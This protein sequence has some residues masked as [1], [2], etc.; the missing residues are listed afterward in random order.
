MIDALIALW[1][2]TVQ[3]A[4][5]GSGGYTCHLSWP[6]LTTAQWWWLYSFLHIQRPVV[7]NE[8]S[9]EWT[10]L[11]IFNSQIE[12]SPIEKINHRMKACWCTTWGKFNCLISNF[13][14]G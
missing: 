9:A 4:P 11:L 14:R 10:K 6:N 5:D 8:F 2:Q 3:I 1:Q 12:D 13:N 7:L